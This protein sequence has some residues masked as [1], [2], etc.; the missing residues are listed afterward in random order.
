M[1]DVRNFGRRLIE[2]RTKDIGVDL[3]SQLSKMFNILAVCG[4]AVM[5]HSSCIINKSM[6]FGFKRR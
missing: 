4:F 1:V 2:I 3:L 5:S 6:L